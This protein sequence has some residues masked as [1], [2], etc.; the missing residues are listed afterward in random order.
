MKAA[1]ELIS[2]L[3]RNQS[4]NAMAAVA[5]SAST[6]TWGIAEICALADVL[7]RSGA[8]LTFPPN[9]PVADV[10][11]TG[12]PSSLST[13]LCPLFLR[14][15]G[16]I[17][18][19]LG[20]AGRPA[21]G[22]DVLAQLKGYRIALDIEEANDV[23]DRCGYAH[24]LA[25]PK[26]APLDAAL[27]SYRQSVGVQNIPALAAASILSKKIACGLSLAGLDVRVAPY[28]NFGGDFD[29]ARRSA[30]L[31]CGAARLAGIATVAALSDASVPYQPYIGRGESLLA[32]RKIFDGRADPW[33][34]EHLD[35]CHLM[36]AH[37]AALQNS[38]PPSRAKLT[39]HFFENV[40][41]QGGSEENF[42]EKTDALA[43]APRYEI[44]ATRDGFFSIDLLGLRTA[45]IS[46]NQ[47]NKT[48]FPDNLGAVIQKRSGGYVTRDELLATIRL[49]QR[50]I[51]DD[52]Q[53][54]LQECFKVVDLMDHAP[55]IKE[56]VRA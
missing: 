16:Y 10:A 52:L 28:G 43:E 1:L 55:G 56:F 2:E 21:G 6:G 17:V 54:Q 31:F 7:A 51:W 40:E 35:S 9:L 3:E 4:N 53:P 45:I 30:E 8:Y 39:Q 44:R 36:A 24:F 42:Y 46:A 20:V 34:E 19:K 33:L 22:I 41:A 29:T 25:G 37:V 47:S 5:S 50:Q 49:E 15:L 14:E 12:G 32:L 18:P 13:L 26:F 48:Q 11:S 38:L 23:L 27:F